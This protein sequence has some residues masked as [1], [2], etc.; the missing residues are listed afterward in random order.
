MMGRLAA[1]LVLALP[2]AGAAQGYG[3]PLVNNGIPSGVTVAADVGFANDDLGGGTA[4]GVQ[5]QLGLGLVGLSGAV[6][7]LSV[8]APGVD[9]ITSL[10]AAASFRVFG[11][12]LV[13][14]RIVAQ[15]SLANW[16]TDQG[17]VWS[18]GQGGIADVSATRAALS[19]GFAAT[20]PIP[21]LAVKPWL[22][23]R[24]ERVST[25]GGSDTDVAISGGIELGFLNG[26]TI[27]TAYDRVFV[28]R[29]GFSARP[30]VFSVGLGWAL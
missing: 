22:A 20:I 12:P 6:T 27:R 9:P 24:V 29:D 25:G 13:P 1:L 16:S 14:F 11:G 15:G 18:A 7:R 10:G 28:S 26:L 17:G 2:A 5:G 3:L 8:D 30:S 4:Y 19:L 23:P 21:A